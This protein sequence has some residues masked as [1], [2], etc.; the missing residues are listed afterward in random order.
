MSRLME[1]LSPVITIYFENI[2]S[3]IH[4]SPAVFCVIKP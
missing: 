2:I 3:L 4:S 1:A